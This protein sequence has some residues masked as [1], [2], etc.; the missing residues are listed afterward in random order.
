M[1]SL[2]ATLLVTLF[3]AGGDAYAQDALLNVSYDPTR[4]LYQEV[5]EAFGK[6]W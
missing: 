1:K 3:I 6:A 4:E 2:S 5:N